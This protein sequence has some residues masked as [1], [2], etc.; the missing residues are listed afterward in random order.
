MNQ[1]LKEGQGL[2]QFPLLP[3]DETPQLPQQ[4]V[5]P[6]EGKVTYATY[7]CKAARL[8]LPAQTEIHTKPGPI[9]LKKTNLVLP[10]LVGKGVFI[11]SVLLKEITP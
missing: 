4:L 5:S 3:A 6:G 10:I 1:P 11:K 2:K 9:P 8:S 7:Q